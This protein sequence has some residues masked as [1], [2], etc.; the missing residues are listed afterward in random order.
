MTVNI[1][2]VIAGALGFVIALAW[3]DAVNKSIKSFFPVRHEN[4]IA[5][6][7]IIYAILITI[8]VI[9]MVFIINQTKKTYYKYTGK[10]LFDSVDS[11]ES[12]NILSIN[13]T[14]DDTAD[15][16]DSGSIDFNPYT[17]ET[18]FA[19]TYTSGVTTF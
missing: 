13:T 12:N 17:I 9:V 6:V 10:P 2:A 15:L 1:N 7:T 3:N 16:I 19:E 14:I 5:K 11:P 18:Y 8:F 4:D